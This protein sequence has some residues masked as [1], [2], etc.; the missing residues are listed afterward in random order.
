[1]SPCPR[2][3]EV[4]AERD[5]RLDASARERS[6]KHRKQCL[7]CREE[8]QRL[9]GLSALLGSAEKPTLDE[10]GAKRLRRRILSDA[11]A[12]VL[13]EATSPSRMRL[14]IA[15][16][17]AVALMALGARYATRAPLPSTALSLT[18]EGGG[19]YERTLENGVDHVTLHEGS[20]A[21]R[22]DHEAGRSRLLVHVPDGEIEDIGTIFHVTVKDGHTARVRVDEGRVVVRTTSAGGH[23]IVVSAGESWEPPRASASAGAPRE[24]PSVAPP[25][26]SSASLSAA[27][28][29]AVGPGHGTPSTS[30]GAGIR[31]LPHASAQPV[32]PTATAS[33]ASGE[34]AAYLGVLS[35]LHQGRRDA[36]KAAA[37]RYVVLYPNGLRRK[38]M[39]VVA[40]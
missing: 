3:W 11:N 30:V 10:L 12:G 6:Q 26:P 15:S 36:A 22:V 8:H 37:R 34:D 33:S 40:E 5:G 32:A 17:A 35:L 18:D 7:S 39:D 21:F 2:V 4:E 25:A 19:R 16:V 20:M 23:G 13:R 9:E 38:E 28:S 14:G 31:A 1:M 24:E 29:A 27:S